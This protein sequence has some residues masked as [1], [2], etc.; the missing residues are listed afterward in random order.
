MGQWIELWNERI[1]ISD[2][3]GLPFPNLHLTSW[4]QKGFLI[5][6]LASVR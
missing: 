4:I 1:L 5:I 2:F 6:S 3:G